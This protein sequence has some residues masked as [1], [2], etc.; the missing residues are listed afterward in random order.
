M[1]KKII[2]TGGIG[3]IGTELC[4]IY[5]GVSRNNKIIVFDNRFFSERINQLRN[6]GIDFIHGD[7]LDKELVKK[8]FSDADIIHHLAGV[9]DVPRVKS[10]SGDDKDTK[11]KLVGEKGTENIF[12]HFFVC[13]YVLAFFEHFSRSHEQNE[14]HQAVCW[15][16]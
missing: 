4:K 11:I 7:I 12:E 8:H 1:G 2:I 14:P 6:W 3:Y 9:T 13:V 5:S 10:E 16:C 15:V